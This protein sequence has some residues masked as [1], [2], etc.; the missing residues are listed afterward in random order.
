[1]LRCCAETLVSWLATVDAYEKCLPLFVPVSS[2]SILLHC[3]SKNNNILALQVSSFPCPATH[4]AGQFNQCNCFELCAF[5]TGC[6]EN[7]IFFPF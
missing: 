1:M 7:N 5:V 3:I 2:L 6:D 4:E